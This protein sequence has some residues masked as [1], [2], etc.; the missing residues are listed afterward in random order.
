[1]LVKDSLS[2]SYSISIADAEVE[3]IMWVQFVGIDGSE[4]FRGVWG[5]APLGNFWLLGPLRLI[6]TQSGW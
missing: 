6:L 2:E 1:M 3:G 5:H 4:D